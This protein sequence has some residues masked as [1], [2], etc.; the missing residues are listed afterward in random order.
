M[1]IVKCPECGCEVSDKA[2]ICHNCGFHLINNFDDSECTIIEM[3]DSESSS[4]P[5]FGNNPRNPRKNL[6]A[7]V[8]AVIALCAGGF[9]SY[10]TTDDGE[11][12][13]GFMRNCKTVYGNYKFDDMGNWISRTATKTFQADE[14]R[15]G[16]WETEKNT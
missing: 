12:E 9:L 6:I 8:V 16:H 7:I 15:D 14:I 1:A 4:H 2:S 10:T 3:P 13:L 5:S 11:G